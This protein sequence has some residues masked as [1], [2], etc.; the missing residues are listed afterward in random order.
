MLFSMLLTAALSAQ[1]PPPRPAPSMP[2]RDAAPVVVPRLGDAAALAD[3]GNLD[4][5][6]HAFQQIAAAN[7]Q[8]R[9][10]RLWIARLHVRMGHPDRAESV[11]RSVMLED[12]ADVRATVG[13]GTTLIAL[14]E[15]KA[16]IDVLEAA[17]K[18]AP[19]NPDVLAALGKAYA[20]SG[21]EDR[22]IGYLQRAV[23]IDPNAQNRRSL[24]RA[25]L[26]SDHRSSSPLS[27]NSS[28]RTPRSEIARTRQPES[29]SAGSRGTPARRT[30]AA[31]HCRAGR[32]PARGRSR[33]AGARSG[34]AR[35]RRDAGV[36]NA[37]TAGPR[38]PVRRAA[39]RRVTRQN[40]PISRDGTHSRG[41]SC[42]PEYRDVEQVYTRV[43]RRPGTRAG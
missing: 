39:C 31:P 14:Q 41:R 27:T 26:A 20:D 16:A 6:L 17:E 28:S 8:N 29:R 25:R 23:V 2:V 7:P 32:P 21:R 36:G 11:Y 24:E 9:E 35:R 34:R 42:R 12:P 18:T 37:R 15:Y 22:S 30:G 38:A 40:R 43:R 3:A 19:R 5:A 13:V 4:E 1:A 33:S 10:A